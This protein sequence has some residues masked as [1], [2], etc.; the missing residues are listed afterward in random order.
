MTRESIKSKIAAL[1]AK[2]EGTDNQF[3]AATFMAKVN[4]LLERHQ[5]EMHEIRAS[6]GDKDPMGFQKGETNIYASAI[7]IRNVGG[8]LAVLYGCTLIY[9]RMGNHTTYDVVGRESS[10]TTFE[11]MLPFIVSQVRVQ[12]KTLISKGLTKSVAEREVAQALEHRIWLLSRKAV[13]QREVAVGKG[14]IP[15][16]DLKAAVAEYFPDLKEARPRNLD[17]GRLAEEQAAK[18]SINIQ[19]TDKQDKKKVLPSA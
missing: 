14:L 19:A 4:E 5:M 11:L 7:W 9:R 13:E 17:F 16:S 10:R 15:V 2:A 3:E 1:L 12:A 6:M 8:A 18:I